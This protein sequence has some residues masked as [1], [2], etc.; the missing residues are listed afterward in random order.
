VQRYREQGIALWRT[1]G[2]GA[3]TVASGDAA[4]VQATREQLTGYWHRW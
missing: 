2:S 1:D 3:I 4:G